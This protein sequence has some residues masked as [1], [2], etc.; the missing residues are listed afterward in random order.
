MLRVVLLE[1]L[2]FHRVYKKGFKPRKTVAATWYKHAW[3]YFQ[4]FKICM[5][6][7]ID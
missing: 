4:L 7:Y 5:F 1:P 3:I 6:L 2:V